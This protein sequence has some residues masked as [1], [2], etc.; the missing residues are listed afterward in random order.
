M[1]ESFSLL[2]RQLKLFLCHGSEDKPAVRQL[3]NNLISIGID[4]WL[5]EEKILPGQD[6]QYEISKAVRNSDIIVICLS[7]TSVNKTGYVQKEIKYALDIAEEKP[8]GTIFLIPARLENCSVP[9]RLSGKQW[10]NLFEEK[11]FERLLKSLEAYLKSN[12]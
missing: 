4:A 5:D 8:E 2:N 10:V 11:G 12:L 9:D 3:Y 6:W 7:S 1:S